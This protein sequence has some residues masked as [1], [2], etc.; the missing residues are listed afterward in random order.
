MLGSLFSNAF[1]YNL[2][3]DIGSLNIRAGINPNEIIHVPSLLVRVE[4]GKE[5]LGTRELVGAAAKRVHEQIKTHG[6]SPLSN[7]L[8][9]RPVRRGVVGSVEITERVL[10]HVFCGFPKKSF[11]TRPF[12]LC[13]VSAHASVLEM[14]N[15]IEAIMQAGARRAEL[16]SGP[17]AVCVQHSIETGAPLGTTRLVIELGEEI[18]GM[19]IASSSGVLASRRLPFGMR[20][21]VMAVRGHLNRLGAELTTQDATDKLINEDITEEEITPAL[22]PFLR[23]IADEA[24]ELIARAPEMLLDDLMKEGI[25]LAGAPAQLKGLAQ[26]LK[27]ELELDVTVCKAPENIRTRGLASIMQNNELLDRLV[28]GEY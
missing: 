27:T 16:V 8:L 13:G 24:K 15:I 22:L 20:E 23:L 1:K 14:Q 4:G 17:S 5:S 2:A 6:H 12:V 21:L 7:M 26:F 25:L 10:R 19:G 11:S 3:L 9:L 28:L 18:I